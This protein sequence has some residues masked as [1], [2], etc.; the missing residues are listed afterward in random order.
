MVGELRQFH[1]DAQ[2]PDIEKMPADDELYG[3]L[4]YVE[5]HVGAL[6]GASEQV[7]R[8]AALKRVLLWEYLREQVDLHQAR[9]VEA[10]RSA[11]AEW[12]ALVPVLA[13]GTPSAAYNKAKRLQASTLGAEAL[14]GRPVR[15]T[16]EAV[17][18]AER[19]I[20]ARALAERR[21][22]E[23]ARKR[24]EL[25]APVAGRLVEQRAGFV[26]DEDA[27]YWLDEVAAVLGDCRTPTQQVSLGR[28]LEAAV[29][30]LGKV[31]QR[32][33]RP[34]TTTVEAGLAYAAALELVSAS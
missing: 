31:Q 34:V 13:V 18:E 21:A 32:T 30:A 25:L 12:A 29:R 10:A 1:E 33:A 24:H 8:A 15:R 23:A 26:E 20:A 3:A 22:Q 19:Q 11:K 27:A 2:D 16:P 17:I 6:A 7:Q 14:G 9:A 28:Y 4:L 5:K